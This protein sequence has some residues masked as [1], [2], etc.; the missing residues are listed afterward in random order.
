M[1]THAADVTRE[2]SAKPL[3][4][5]GRL[6]SSPAYDKGTWSSPLDF[7]GLHI[8]PDVREV[9]VGQRVVEL[10]R[11][12][13]DLLARLASAPRKVFSRDELLSDVWQSCREWQT[14][15]TVTEHVRRIRLKLEPDNDGSRWIQTVP[16]AGYRFEP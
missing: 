3:T 9:V 6:D 1:N 11:R 8:D 12:E 10:T 5:A 2:V 7:N 14:P 16:G 13:F 4:T 15:K